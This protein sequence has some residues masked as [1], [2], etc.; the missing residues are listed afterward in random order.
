[1]KK[2]SKIGEYLKKKIKMWPK[3]QKNMK[4]IMKISHKN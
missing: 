3:S 2:N 4:K 1:M